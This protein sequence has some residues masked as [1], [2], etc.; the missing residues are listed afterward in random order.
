MGKSSDDFSIRLFPY[1]LGATFVTI[2]FLSTIESNYDFAKLNLKGRLQ[3]AVQY[4]QALIIPR[5][6]S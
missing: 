4:S 3:G 5:I 6:S 2:V 1:H